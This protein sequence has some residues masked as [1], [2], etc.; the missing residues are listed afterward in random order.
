MQDLIEKIKKGK[1]SSTSHTDK[2]KDL[3]Q[4]KKKFEKIVLKYSLNQPEKAEEIAKFLTK[5]N[6]VSVKEFA[7]LFAIQEDEAKTFLSFID[8][9][10]K[11]KE[12]H[13]DKK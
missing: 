12:E 3:E 6:T 9:G 1:E 5:G 8:K 13:I 2:M 10:I 4:H 7:T 11:F